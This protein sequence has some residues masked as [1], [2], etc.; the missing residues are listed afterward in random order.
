MDVGA[1]AAV[2]QQDV[3]SAPAEQLGHGALARVERVAKVE[4]VAAMQRDHCRPRL[5]CGN[6]QP[7]AENIRE[8]H[9]HR[10]GHRL[11]DGGGGKNRGENHAYCRVQKTSEERHAGGLHDSQVSQNSSPGPWLWQISPLV[12]A[13][14]PWPVSRRGDLGVR[15]WLSTGETKISHNAQ[16]VDPTLGNPTSVLVYGNLDAHVLELFGR[17]NFR[18]NLVPQGGGGRGAHQP[19]LL[20]G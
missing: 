1:A 5:R 6:R 17:E 13:Q 2:G 12:S 19:R 20:R 14:E 7:P 15:Y 10:A 16:G 18:N 11:R 9:L 4:P 3:E 8:A